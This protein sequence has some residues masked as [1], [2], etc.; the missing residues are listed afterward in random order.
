LDDLIAGGFLK[1]LEVVRDIH[2]LRDEGVAK[3]LTNAIR[4]GFYDVEENE[5]VVRVPRKKRRQVEKWFE[6]AAALL[7]A[8][9]VAEDAVVDLVFLAMVALVA[10]ER[11]QLDFPTE[12]ADGQ[13]EDRASAEN[14]RISDFRALIAGCCHDDIDRRIV[15]MC[16]EENLTHAEIGALLGLGK[17]AFKTRFD[18]LKARAT[19]LYERDYCGIENKIENKEDYPALNQRMPAICIW[20][21]RGRQSRQIQAAASR[22]DRRLANS[23]YSVR[24]K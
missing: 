13:T 24:C 3:Y 6:T 4:N 18:R 10:A 11:H 21:G 7:A 14:I 17:D 20:A 9:A 1:V 22:A 5:Q 23:H 19:Y 15:K 16:E 12:E 2:L 8:A